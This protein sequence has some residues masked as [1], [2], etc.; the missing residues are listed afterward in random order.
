MTLRGVRTWL[1]NGWDTR[2]LRIDA[3]FYLLCTGYSI[4]LAVS[5]QH[6]GFRVWAVFATVGYGCALLHTCWVG[7]ASRSS[8][9]RWRSRWAGVGLIAVIGMLGPLVTLVIQRVSGGDWSQDPGTWRAQPEVWVIERAGGLLLDHGSPYLDIDALPHPPGVYDYTPYGPVMA[10]FGVPRAG[11]GNT[12]VGEALTDARLVFCLTAVLCLWIS[13]RLLGRPRVPVRAAQLV[14]VFPLTALTW[15]TAGPDLAIV[16]L[17]ILTAAL[18]VTERI[19][20]AG[21]MI[22]LAVSAKLI[23]LPAAVVFAFLVATRRGTS[24]LLRY[25][26]PFVVVSA[27]V[28]IPVVVSDPGAF[29]ENVLRFPAGLGVVSSPAESPLPG[30]LL[31]TT[32]SFGRGAAY[33]LVGVAALTILVWLIRRPPRIGSDALVRVAVG[34]GAFVLLTPATRFGYLLYPVVLLG[35]ALVLAV[36]VTTPLAPGQQPCTVT[37]PKRTHSFLARVAPP[38]PR[39]W[40]PDSDNTR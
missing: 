2:P 16:A 20:A 23:V 13:L 14:A 26:T 18:V 39:S 3:V 22:G 36:R 10:L 11:F 35:A 38:R 32:G 1:R 40:T 37:E 8:P 31:A 33:A 9:T 30:Y 21:V 19:G 5:D 17:V 4:A 27:V 6:Y 7:M 24:A 28:T 34:L 12:A 25:V 15:A 29:V